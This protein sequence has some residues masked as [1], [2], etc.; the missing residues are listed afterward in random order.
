MQTSIC[1]F[2][3]WTKLLLWNRKMWNK[4]YKIFISFFNIH[5]HIDIYCILEKEVIL[6]FCNFFCFCICN[7]YILLLLL[8][9][10]FSFI[11][12]IYLFINGLS[13]EW[14]I[15]GYWFFVW[16]LMIQKNNTI[17]TW[18]EFR[19]FRRSDFLVEFPTEQGRVKLA[20]HFQNLCDQ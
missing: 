8:A 9:V 16:T 11:L 1:L 17:F 18:E 14:N 4:K 20:E 19:K 15:R 3:L 6:Y 13:L 2:S 7:I 12:V 10:A 5:H